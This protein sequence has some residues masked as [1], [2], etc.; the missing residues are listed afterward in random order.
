M[1]A[2][3]G[4]GHSK[5]GKQPEIPV[6]D[7]AVQPYL[8][9]LT[10]ALID[11]T[12]IDMLIIGT[13]PEYHTQRSLGGIIAE[14]L[15]LNSKPVMLTEAAC[16]SGSA[17][18][19][20]ASSYVKAGLAKT[21]CVL[22]I[23]KMSELTTAQ[24]LGLMGRVGDVQWESGLGTTFPGYYALF[25]Q[26]HFKKYNTTSED[27]ALISLKNH[28]YG[29]D[30]PKA[31]FFNKRNVTLEKILNSNLVADPLKVYDCCANADG[32]VVTIVQR[33]DAIKKDAKPVWI[34]GM[35]VA[36]APM[37]VLTRKSLTEIESTRIAAHQ[38]YQM[39]G[40]RPEDIDVAD[41]HDCFTIA[42][43]LAYEDLGFCEKGKGA[44]FIQD[45]EST[46]EGS[47]PVN[48]DG[49][50]KSKGHPVGAT[51][52]SMIYTIVKQ[53]RGEMPAYQVSGAK[54]G[55]THNIGGIG[56]YCYVN[57]LENE[58]PRT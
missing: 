39:S 37:S 23:Q 35:G 9:A 25:A 50:L 36:S 40:R 16:A 47:I 18:L 54:I 17:A 2:I 53:L 34:T 22:G 13:S 1:L 31:M 11:P 27:L 41:V 14:N 42:E 26:R 33:E 46:Y 4:V 45:A 30:N 58:K 56:Q 28:K 43:L 5:F 20:I 32:A 38:A 49:G 48:V 10:D 6:Q 21:V 57:I 51:G 29:A 7:L 8:D 15:G 44:K 12:E 52:L 55:L 19:H 3:T 24:T